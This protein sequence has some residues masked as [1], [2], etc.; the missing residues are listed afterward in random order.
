MITPEPVQAVPSARNARAWRKRE[1]LGLVV[2][3]GLCILGLALLTFGLWAN[4][5]SEVRTPVASGAGRSSD[6]SSV[7]G[8]SSA[9]VSPRLRAAEAAVV[10]I[11]AEL[12]SCDRR[13]E[14]SGFVYAPERVLTNAHNVAGVSG[15]VT[16]NVSGGRSFTGVVV[17]FDPGRDVAVLRV[18][19]LDIPPLRFQSTTRVGDAG[20]IV[21]NAGRANVTATSAKIISRMVVSGGNIFWENRVVRKIY[22]IGGQVVPGESGGPLLA[23]DGTVSGVVFAS[24][25]DEEDR[26]Y[27]LTAEEVASDALTG[28]TAVRAVSTSRCSK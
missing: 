28:R 27:V 13:Q 4:D 11:V 10:G 14:G 6:G 19:G 22:V 21:E 15:S 3:L 2:A 16:V 24:A 1:V 12:R 8:G 20:V 25:L 17:L 18:P 9:L 26:G 23:L 7:S 5:G